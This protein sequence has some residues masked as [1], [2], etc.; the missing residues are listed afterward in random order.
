MKQNK[1]TRSERGSARL[2]RRVV[3]LLLLAVGM[4]VLGPALSVGAQT[5]EP[6]T[7][8]SSTV[9]VPDDEAPDD[10]APDDGAPDEEA[11][12]GGSEDEV[13]DPTTTTTTT[14]TTTAPAPTAENIT[15]VFT[16][17]EVQGECGAREQV[18]K[19]Y[20]GSP[21]ESFHMRIV[22]EAP[23][24]EP[25]EAKAAIYAM[26]E[27]GTEPWP[28]TLVETLPFTIQE[29]GTYDVTFTKTCQRVQFDVLTGDTPQVIQPL[30]E[31][32]G[33]LL[34][35]FDVNTSLQHWGC[36][37]E[38]A[39]ITEERP[40]QLALTGSTSTGTAVAG[41]ALLVAGAAV[42]LAARR[43]STL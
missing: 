15:V 7:S 9:S 1:R 16:P 31:W 38:V 2:E 21:P 27:T 13:E 34:F 35:P 12:D 23:L 37:V 33:P 19:N 41:G 24:C 5:D 36:P 40:A 28:Q 22:A 20:I 32:H 10:E 6:T 17:A 25:I 43:R 14:T 18:L 11:P 3:G 42:L 8:T 26:P 30:G 4:V 29:A 39:G